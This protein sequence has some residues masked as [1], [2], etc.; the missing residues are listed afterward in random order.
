MAIR[1]S[2]KAIILH[3]G[4]ILLNRCASRDGSA[5]YDLPG[6]GQHTY[7][8]LEQAVVREVLEETGYRVAVDRFVALSEEIYDDP[9]TRRRYPE[10][11]HRIAHIFLA[12]L[13][14]ETVRDCSEPDLDQTGSFWFS[15]E[16]AD[17]LPMAPSSLNGR[18]SELISCGHPIDLGCTRIAKSVQ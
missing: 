12:H 6:G 14:D 2:S 4:K 8:T 3:E 9:D 5:Y 18:L 11:T 7:E 16:E 1:C 15:A 10:Y 17:R 13:E